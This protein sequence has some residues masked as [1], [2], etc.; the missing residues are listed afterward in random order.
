VLPCPAI[1][2]CA[3]SFERRLQLTATPPAH[4]E[5]AMV[6]Y[7]GHSTAPCFMYKRQLTATGMISFHVERR[8]WENVRLLKIVLAKVCSRI[9]KRSASVC[10]VSGRTSDALPMKNRRPGELNNIAISL[11]NRYW[12][13]KLEVRYRVSCDAVFLEVGAHSSKEGISRPQVLRKIHK[14]RLS[15]RS[16]EDSPCQATIVLQPLML[17]QFLRARPHR[18]IHPKA[19]LM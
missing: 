1:C 14:I 18:R 19:F 4:S 7:C 11:S 9:S 5:C 13:T 15:H 8:R 17:K 12:G 2:A 6:L 16:Y 10:G 3:G